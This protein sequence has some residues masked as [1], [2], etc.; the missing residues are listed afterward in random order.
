MVSNP[1]N[2]GNNLKSHFKQFL[3]LFEDFEL[4]FIYLIGYT[5]TQLCIL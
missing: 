5:A 4:L 2:L 1:E 3:R